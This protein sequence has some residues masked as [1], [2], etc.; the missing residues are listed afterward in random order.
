MSPAATARLKITLNDV[1]P[2]VTRRL[3]VQITNRSA[4]ALAAPKRRS[5]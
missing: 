2:V 1:K 4:G 3:E 5:R